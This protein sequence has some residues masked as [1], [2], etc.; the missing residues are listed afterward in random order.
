MS[1]RG[2][3]KEGMSEGV[4][5]EG[6]VVRVCQ[7]GVCHKGGVRSVSEGVCQKE[8]VRRGCVGSVC[9]KKACRKG[10]CQRG[11]SEGCMSEGD[12]ANTRRHELTNTLEERG[13][14]AHHFFIGNLVLCSN[15][16]PGLGRYGHHH[17]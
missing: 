16:G 3:A 7:K 8:C 12:D 5:Q 14:L 4:C 10:V 11:V 9:Q 2:V 17:S 1:E 15:G 13:H 6:C